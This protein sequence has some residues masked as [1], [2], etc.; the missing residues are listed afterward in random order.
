[1]PGS[2]RFQQ[3]G[4]SAP[5]F[6]N[7]PFQSNSV[8]AATSLGGDT[9]P[10]GEAGTNLLFGSVYRKTSSNQTVPRPCSTRIT[11][12][13]ASG[14]ILTVVS[15]G[16]QSWLPF[17]AGVEKSPSHFPFLSMR[18]SLMEAAPSTLRVL[19]Y[20]LRYTVSLAGN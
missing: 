15:Y 2:Y 16:V 7:P 18:R 19:I 10:L 5:N 6:S 9:G 4:P 8:S 20:P 14:G 13:C 11:A 3:R 1:M 12:P 17:T